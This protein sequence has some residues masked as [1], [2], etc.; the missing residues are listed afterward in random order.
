MLDYLTTTKAGRFS[1]PH[2]V[3]NA[4]YRMAALGPNALYRPGEQDPH[5]TPS[6]IRACICIE[7]NGGYRLTELGEALASVL[8]GFKMKK[9]A[10]DLSLADVMRACPD[11]VKEWL[12]SG[13]PLPRISPPGPFFEALG[14]LAPLDGRFGLSGYSFT[15]AGRAAFE[16]FKARQSGYSKG[17]TVPSFEEV[18]SVDQITLID[19]MLSG[20]LPRPG[21]VDGRVMRGVG[22]GGMDIITQRENGYYVIRPELRPVI[23]AIMHGTVKDAK[24]LFLMF[25]DTDKQWFYTKFQVPP[26]CTRDY[27]FARLGWVSIRVRHRQVYYTEAGKILRERLDIVDPVSAEPELYDPD[28]DEFAVDLG[29]VDTDDDFDILGPSSSGARASGPSLTEDQEFDII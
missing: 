3:H 4:V 21:D 20:K 14:V 1:L 2:D 7:H 12:C 18:F 19:D 24:R 17:M 6:M 10:P 26:T 29:P 9:R 11:D 23:E 22:P 5:V 28:H 15:D 27:L 8:D 13:L 16:A 25:P